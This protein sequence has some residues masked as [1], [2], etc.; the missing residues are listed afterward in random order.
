MYQS[1]LPPGVN[2]GICEGVNCFSQAEVQIDVKVGQLRQHI[3]VTL[4]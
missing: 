2:N 4:Q 1:K 3:I